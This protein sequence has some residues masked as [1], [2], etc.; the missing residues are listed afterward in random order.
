M[1]ATRNS[2]K[3]KPR[4]APR[5]QLSW[6]EDG[7]IEIARDSPEDQQ[8]IIEALVKHPDVKVRV[9]ATPY[10]RDASGKS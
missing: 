2:G 7:I 5:C 8:R 1:E 6:T 9:K 3:Q 4:E 10:R